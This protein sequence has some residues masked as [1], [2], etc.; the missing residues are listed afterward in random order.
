MNEKFQA[1]KALNE[2]EIKEKK[3]KLDSCPQRLIVT[4]SSRCNLDCIMCE[5]RR[6]KWDIPYKVIQEVVDFFPYLESIIWQGGEPFLL[7]Y[8]GEIFD[9]AS[10][11]E[12][13]K[14]MIVTN[15]LLINE[16][17]VEKLA[18]NNVELTFSIDGVT[19]EVYEHIRQGAKFERV[20]R[21]LT[22]IKEARKKYDSRNMTLRLHVVVMKSNYHQLED[23]MNFA[24]EYGFAAVHLISMGG[25]QSEEENIFSRQ[26]NAP[27]T[28]LEGI[29]DKLE[30]KA[31]RLNIELLNSLPRMADNSKQCGSSPCSKEDNSNEPGISCFAPWQQMNLDPGGGIR[32][33]CLCLKT[34]G[35][36]F[37]GRLKDIWN[38]E[39]MQ[40]YRQK[41]IAGEFSAICNSTCLEVQ[42]SEQRR[43]ARL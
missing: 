32:P 14:Q 22:I 11:F 12:Q 41:M 33:G 38:S 3:T 42:I 30:E 36:V 23:F 24:H 16:A 40:F 15:G 8:F 34:V 21:S 43:K 35:T 25:S 27:L 37:E 1:N 7:E 18:K 26:E 28:Y 4:L 19:R 17:W 5:V 6:T 10:K 29:R 9:E 13:L 20:I 39:A 2:R 31:R